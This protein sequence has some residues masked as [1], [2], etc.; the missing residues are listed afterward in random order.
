MSTKPDVWMPLYI[1]DYLRDTTRLTTEKHGAYFLLIMDYWVNGAPPDDDEVLASITKM[2]VS[3]WKKAR[4]ALLPLFTIID[5]QW[6]HKRVD[7]ELLKAS[8]NADKYSKR[9][10]KAAAKRWEKQSLEDATCNA[11]SMQ[12]ALHEDM[13]GDAT[14]PSPSSIKPN[15]QTHSVENSNTVEPSLAASVCLALK[16]HG[17]TDI[18]PAHPMLLELLKAGATLDQFNFAAATAKVKKFNYIVATVKGQREQAAAESASLAK[19]TLK[20]VDTAWRSDDNAIVRKAQEL[21]IAT[22]GKTRPQLLTEI[23]AKQEQIDRQTAR[24][25]KAA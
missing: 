6:R 18:N 17:I 22:G 19:G 13:H 16:E 8:E 12:Q 7:E 15:E 1:G 25:E 23:D 3:A 10:K 21:K 2:Q 24:G 9:G 5:G 11:S 4:P 20:I 14:S